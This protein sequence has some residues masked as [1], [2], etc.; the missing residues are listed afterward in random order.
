VGSNPTLSLSTDTNTDTN[1]AKKVREL[2]KG[3]PSVEIA[4]SP[5]DACR[6]VAL[7]EEQRRWLFFEMPKG[8]R[9]KHLCYALHAA[10]P[11]GQCRRWY[12]K[13]SVRRSPLEFWSEVLAYHIGYELGIEV[14]V[15]FPAIY[16]HRHGSLSM[17]ML[18]LQKDSALVEGADVLLSVDGS[19]DRHYGEM[20]SVQRVLRAFRHFRLGRFYSDFYRQLIFDAVLGNKDRHHENWG[21]LVSVNEGAPPTFRLCP[22]FD[23]GSSLLREFT[24]DLELTNRFGSA[25]ATDDYIDRGTSLVKWEAD[26]Q[27]LHL[28][29]EDLLERHMQRW[30]ASIEVTRAVLMNDSSAVAGAISRV[31]TLSRK[32]KGVELSNIREDALIRVTLRRLER[33]KD[34]LAKCTK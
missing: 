18:T 25:R 13:T 10:P 32:F 4:F 3:V 28:R 21:F 19:Y 6:R 31:C 12:F 24:S 26:G 11:D 34:L 17:D 30:P 7:T 9:E 20:Q 14:P 8:Q 23:N 2:A 33:L 15:C 16:G 22:A 1:R 27:Y 29:H 5:K